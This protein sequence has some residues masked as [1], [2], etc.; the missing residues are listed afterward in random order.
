M[1]CYRCGSHV[2]DGAETCWNCGTRLAGGAQKGG[3]TL[4]ELRERQRTKSRLSGVVYKI[5]D[6][7]AGRYKVRD[8]GGSGGVG[9]VYRAHDQE[10]DVDVALKVVNAKLLQTA[11]EKR[12]F[13]REIKTAKKLN[14]QNIVRIYDEGK[15][16]ERA[17]VTMQFLEGLSLRKIIDL[18][19][20]KKQHFALSEI[21]PIYNQLCQA[22]DYAHRT[23]FHGSLK[24]DNIL[25]LPDLLK[26]TDFGLLRGLPRKP[27]LAI[28]KSR[29]PNFQ[30][31]APEVRLEVEDLTPAV[32]LYSLG[33]ILA[34]MLTGQLVDESKPELLS[35][36]KTGLDSGILKVVRRCL[37]R[38]PKERYPTAGELY[39]D[40]RTILA[41]G[42][43]VAR[44]SIGPA[45]AKGVEI[46][47][48]LIAEAPKAEAALAAEA[49]PAPP[50]AEAK[51]P[52][53]PPVEAETEAPTQRLDISKHGP[54]PVPEEEAPPKRASIPSVEALE[55]DGGTG[56]F[57]AIDD[58]MIESAASRA[59]STIE[60][61]KDPMAAL[62]VPPL[63]EEEVEGEE[64][65]EALE[66]MQ[67]LSAS[68]IVLVADP[69][70]TNVIE[71]DASS[72]QAHIKVPGQPAPLPTFTVPEPQK[73]PVPDAAFL[74]GGSQAGESTQAGRL[75]VPAPPSVIV[76]VPKEE[77]KKEEPKKEEPKPPKKPAPPTAPVIRGMPPEELPRAAKGRE[78]EV[79]VA[80]VGELQE[81]KIIPRS[82][83]TAMPNTHTN[84]TNGANGSAVNG[85]SARARPMTRP[86][87]AALRPGTESM[88]S[89][90]GLF[91]EI[92]P[93]DE[94]KDP[95]GSRPLVVGTDGIQ[96]KPPTMVG[97]Q[98]ATPSDKGQSR[99]M[100]MVIGGVVMG[101]LA[102]LIV[103][104]LLVKGMFDKT[105]EQQ[106]HQIALLTDQIKQS[107]TVASNAADNE[108]KAAQEKERAAKEALAATNAAQEAAKQA[109][110]ENKKK[111][112]AL[113][114]AKALEKA[115]KA[116]EAEEKRRQADEADKK[117]KE[118]L[119]KSESEEKRR[120]S[121]EA[122]KN[123]AEAR[124]AKER[125]A[126]ADAEARAQRLKDQQDAIAKKDAE[127][128]ER[129]RLAEEA[130]AKKEAEKE[131][132]KR[133]E[134][135]AIAKKKADDEAKKAAAEEAKKAAEEK[136]K[137]TDEGGEGAGLAAAGAAGKNCPKGMVF[138][139][140]GSFMIGAPRNDPERN[141]GDKTYASVDVG[142]YCIDYYEAPNGRGRLP[143]TK[144]TYAAAE[145]ACKEKQKRLCSEEEWEKACKGPSGL[146]YPYGNQWDPSLCAT[147]D[148]EG[149]DR[150]IAKSGT[151]E[152][153]RSGFNVLDMS[154]NVAEWTATK[155]EGGDGYVVKGGSSDRPGYDGR[156]AARKK[157]P[158][159][160]GADFLGY[161][162]CADPK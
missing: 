149:N 115:A 134:E 73:A 27:F 20:D 151:F 91:K 111:L 24:P 26:V 120:A 95:T 5:G 70:A 57:A 85:K 126:R 113:E 140:A 3:A 47:S 112:A 114:E 71:V 160:Q 152:K 129:L 62:P 142:A 92:S 76:E 29:M 90:T 60:V 153:C 1:L 110:E 146:R 123:D 88:P 15:D 105:L 124:E 43:V 94:T 159:A 7:I 8:I 108:A 14:H 66:N 49:A 30:Y 28:Q 128:A 63:A 64:A 2:Q 103:G 39:E 10:I 34:E 117:Q 141:F 101:F 82:P 19:K 97:V 61:P 38:A 55:P 36:A 125:Q 16:G 109:E 133:A 161:R 145:K 31:L 41:K 130:A 137:G 74:R 37:L 104:G 42:D 81:P 21:E 32:D 136:K 116:K 143:V 52:S 122:K 9:V 12:L 127:K 107:Q 96:P 35:V 72:G 17:F 157:R 84:G 132:R 98:A 78:G 155:W 89:A 65:T 156:C 48:E 40:L 79:T 154:G 87:M 11:E 69:R 44:S 99:T 162:C 144:V 93:K 68:E 53:P 75:D 150:E 58:D 25:V 23:T 18:R 147:E 158:G 67:E 139:D 22:L 50:P 100:M 106:Q 77:A 119:A 102:L 4:E 118:A 121:E 138:I 56:T 13:S 86:R 135:E 80:P 46:E 131:A 6:V 59:P 148:D 54:R 83:T 45:D 33:V 51:A